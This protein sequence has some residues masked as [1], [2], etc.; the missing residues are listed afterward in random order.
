MPKLSDLTNQLKEFALNP[1]ISEE[2]FLNAFLYPFVF[3]GKITNKNHEEYYLNKARTSEIMNQK[4]DV[5]VKLRKALS[6][7][8]I[9]EKT[10][11]EM[12]PFL[13]DYIDLNRQT[14]LL[15]K[16]TALAKAEGVL[17]GNNLQVDDVKEALSVILTELLLKAVSE[18]NL[19][20]TDSV[21]IWKHGLN[22]IDVQTGDLFRFGFD[23][24][25]KKKD[26]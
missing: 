1:A 14:I 6:I 8:E 26:S 9:K 19:A 11:A 13:E 17:P 21:L 16:C 2:E 10:I 5:P 24:R 22:S 12:D 25:H 4:A 20:K 18:S 7:F 23:N 3:A 15:E